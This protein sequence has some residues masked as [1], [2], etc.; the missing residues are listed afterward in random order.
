MVSC[1]GYGSFSVMTVENVLAF[2]SRSFVMLI[3]V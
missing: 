3:T 2:N 1:G